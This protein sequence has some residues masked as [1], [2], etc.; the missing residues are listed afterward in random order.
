MKILVGSRSSQLARWQADRFI[1][2]LAAQGY[3]VVW[4]GI[5]TRGDLDQTTPLDAFGERGVF[6]KAL[7]L[8]LL[9]GEIDLAVHSLKD[10]PSSMPEGLCLAAVLPRDFH[11]DMLI[12]KP[13]FSFGKRNT[14]ATSSSRRKA[15]WL[16]KYP[17]SNIVDVRGN[18]DSRLQKFNQSDWD[19]MILSRAGL[20]R[21]GAM[22]QH[23]QFLDWMVP[24]PTQ[25]IV[26]AYSA[27]ANMALNVLLKGLEDAKTRFIAELERNFM[28]IVE[29][30]CNAPV[31]AHAEFLGETKIRF[32]AEVYAMN[33]NL[34]FQATEVLH[35]A[36]AAET[37][38]ALA[39]KARSLI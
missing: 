5:Q 33:G 17:N 9:N 34:A 26:A 7:D 25:G 27:T 11:E 20:E 8:A 6:T 16:A 1:E 13:G 22:P 29:M 36:D 4:K 14:I 31:A 39:Q 19:G 3:E 10:C 38:E 21:L 30:K 18:V 23:F 28:R 2:L 15:Q 24:A 12:Q 35:K 32:R 37:V